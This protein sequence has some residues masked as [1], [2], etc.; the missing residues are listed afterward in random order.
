MTQKIRD[1]ANGSTLMFDKW[2]DM[3]CT[4]MRTWIL[5]SDMIQS[6]GLP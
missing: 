6:D 2:A 3:S 5:M 4:Q 1:L